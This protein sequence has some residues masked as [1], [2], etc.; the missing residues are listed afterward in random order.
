M[1]LWRSKISWGI[2]LLTASAI[3]LLDAMREQALLDEVGYMGYF[4]GGLIVAGAYFWANAMLGRYRGEA[5]EHGD[6]A[7][8][9]KQPLKQPRRTATAA[10]SASGAIDRQMI[11]EQIRSNLNADDV[12]D[13]VFDLDLYEN[14]VINPSQDM[15]QVILNLME[16]AESNGKS[17]QLAMSVERI[18]TPV[19]R[20]NLPRLVKISAETPPALLRQFMIAN[21][22][23]RELAQIATHLGIDW[24]ELGTNSKKSRVREL[25]L[26]LQ[27]RNQTPQLIRYLHDFTATTSVANSG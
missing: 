11:F 8:P 4:L 25:L 19:P 7:P 17:P 18:L 2:G 1:F 26:H 9:S 6:E 21:Y 14:D 15:N 10:P 22:N 20:E 12:R 24:E 13:L 16:S 23:L 3:V 5:H 27:R